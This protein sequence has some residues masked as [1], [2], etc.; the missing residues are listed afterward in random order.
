MTI[1]LSLMSAGLET[2]RSA[3]GYIFHH[4]ATH[5]E[6]RRRLTADPS[7]TPKAVEEFIR[8]YPIVFQG[9]RLVKEDIEFHGCPMQ[10]GDVLWI[11]FGSSNTDPRKFE[12]PDEFKF[13]RP[14]VGNHLGFG[15]GPHRCLGMHL[16]RHELIIAIDEWHKR[17]PDYELA[18]SDEL[19]ERGG[20]R[21][22]NGLPLRGEL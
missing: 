6:D 16:A 17:I 4:L 13:D 9:G 3:L 19:L 10:K 8:L 22:L 21:L 20:M 11:G 1:C 2:T 7:L 12:D 5:P 14:N 15:V 18:D